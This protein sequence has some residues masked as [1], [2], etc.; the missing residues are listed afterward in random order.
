MLGWAVAT[1]IG[2]AVVYG[3][4]DD[5]NNERLSTEVAAFY[6]SVHRTAW[7]ICVSW[8]IFTCATGNGGKDK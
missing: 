3:L 5:I 8:V 2:L 1:A 6:N 4:Y 7:G